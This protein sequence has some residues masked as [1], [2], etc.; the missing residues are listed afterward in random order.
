[1]VNYI[2]FT[3]SSV[4]LPS[5]VM[6]TEGADY[7]GFTYTI[8]GITQLQH[9]IEDTIAT[10]AFYSALREGKLP[11][12]SQINAEEFKAAWEPY[13]KNGQDILYYGMSSAIS[14][15]YSNAL[16]AAHQLK[17]EYP[18]RKI[19][20]VDSLSAT[21]MQGIMYYNGLLKYKNGATLEELKLWLEQ[22]RLTSRGLYTTDDL[23]HLKRGGR[24]SAASASLG[25]LLDIKPLLA[26]DREGHVIS[27][28]KV[29]SRKKAFKRIVEELNDNIIKNSGS[30]SDT[31][32]ICQGDC[33]QDALE[34]KEM[35]LK[36]NKDIR[37]VIISDLGITIGTHLGTNCIGLGY[38]GKERSV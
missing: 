8:D 25:T 10:K 18:E 37:N 5:E 22:N 31:V 12:T 34:L 1:M 17:E 3:D 7:I 36:K 26:M 35:I 11:Q 21:G 15:T 32:L 13:L 29:K 2:F 4:D 27:T 9:R 33:M 6:A 23:N 38:I 28:E 24:I 19:E 16:L 20:T 30:M 14:N